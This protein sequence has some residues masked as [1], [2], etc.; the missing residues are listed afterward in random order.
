MPSPLPL[1]TL[2]GRLVELVPLSMDHL[3]DLLRIATDPRESFPY[4]SVA[5]DE[6]GLRAYIALALEDHQK[7]LALPFT[8]RLRASGQV[9]GSTRFG[10][11]ERWDWPPGSPEARFLDG[12]EIGWTWLSPDAQRT[13]VNT[14]AKLLMLTHAFE[15]WGV[16][17][18]TL[19]T[20]RRNERSRAAIARLGFQLDGVLRQNGPGWDG[21]PRDAAH[22]S[23]L[24]S[25]W[26]EAKV[27]LQAKLR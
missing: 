17:R 4:T 1:V 26:P 12:V 24:Q 8:T 6:A 20:D 27:K 19:K 13:G 5:H 21:L 3:P 18:V 16:R 10:R 15:T 7:G 9:L 25:E 14:E 22:F 23:M 2:S 11:A